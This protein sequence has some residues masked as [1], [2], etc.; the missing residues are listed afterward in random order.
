MGNEVVACIGSR[1]YPASSYN[2]IKTAL[3]FLPKETVVVSGGAPGVDTKAISFAKDVG[4]QVRVISARNNDGFDSFRAFQRN[5]EIILQADEVFAFW[6][7]V[8]NGTRSAIQYA[9]QHKKPTTIFLPMGISYRPANVLQLSQGAIFYADKETFGDSGAD[10][11][12]HPEFVE[13]QESSPLLR[14]NALNW[15]V[16]SSGIPNDDN[17]Y[18]LKMISRGLSSLKAFCNSNNISSVAISRRSF[19]VKGIKWMRLRMC[20][21]QY[22]SGARDVVFIVYI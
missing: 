20:L 12:L 16:I 1:H 17:V 5:E 10:A 13:N 19:E 15:I 3:S 22:L 18:D 8:S 9:L 4:L 6:D 11:V 14:L 2:I 7:G 21:E